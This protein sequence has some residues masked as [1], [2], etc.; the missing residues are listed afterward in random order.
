MDNK[1]VKTKLTPVDSGL[2]PAVAGCQL[3]GGEGGVRGQA[4][5]ARERGAA[6]DEQDTRGRGPDLR[7]A[8]AEG[9]GGRGANHRG[10][11]LENR[12]CGEGKSISMFNGFYNVT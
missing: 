12:T 8:A 4:E 1:D 11:R 5:G 9:G 7:P 6:P 10:G 3:T 2:R